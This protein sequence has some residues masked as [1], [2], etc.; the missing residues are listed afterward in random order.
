MKATFLSTASEQARTARL[1]QHVRDAVIML[2]PDGTVGFWSAGAA[3]VY[4]RPAPDALNRPYLDLLPLPCRAAQESLIRQACDGDE[5][6]AEWRTTN[7]DGRPMWLEGDFRP[8][9]DPAGRQVGCS[10][11]LHDVTRWRAAEAARAASEDLLRTV[12]DN[13]PGA[14]F[15]FRVGPDGSRSFTFISRGVEALLE[16]SAAEM[17]AGPVDDSLCIQPQHRP[18]VW[19][20]LERSGES[21][22]P[23]DAEY[24]A[25][26]PRTGQLKWIR[27]RATPARRP[28][29]ATVWNGM[30]KDATD[31]AAA[32]AALRESEARYRLLT[33]HATDLIARLTPGGDF[34]Y[35]SAAT[36]TLFGT[37]PEALIGRHVRELVHRDDLPRVLEVFGHLAAGLPADTFAH[38]CRAADG[39]PVW[40]EST[41]RAVRDAHGHLT[42]IVAVTRSTEDRR[43]LEAKVQKSQRLEAVGRLAGGVAHDFNNLL[44]VINGFS[45]M[46][47]RGLSRPDPTRI[48]AQVQEIHKAGERASGLTRQLL[49]F[50]RQ[51][52]QTRTSVN[53]ND[54]IEE[55]TKL[56]ARVIGEDI[57]VE[58]DLDPD[59]GAIHADVGQIEQVLMNLALNARDA[60]EDG[61]VL[62]LGSRAVRFE[63]AP[64]EDLPPG[65]YAMLRVTDTGTGMDEATRARAFEPFFTT[66]EM[67][68]GTGLGLAV[69]HGIVKQ[70]DGHI[71]IES[72]PGKGTTI[73][74]YLPQ[75]ASLAD[76]AARALAETVLTGQ[77]TVLLVED[78]DAVRMVTAA[79]LRTFGYRVLEA[80]GGVEALRRCRE[81]PGPI[82]VLLTDV[83]MPVMN[84]REVANRVQALVPGV[85]TLFMSGYTDDSILRHGI[86]D[87]GVAFLSKPLSHDALGRKLR[88]VLGSR[89]RLGMTVG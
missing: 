80:S 66:K 69:V 37:P 77:E 5:V 52:V 75:T 72:E 48:A 35:A 53:L 73:R 12:T 87:D 56:L 45:E 9:T 39:S 55:T 57:E 59:L 65:E 23:W 2:D 20:A 50:G 32:L 14:V 62:T 41:A 33:E 24:L 34:L 15:Q 29:G 51:Q 82:H 30:M 27:L 19:A 1:F 63:T 3:R 61:G 13:V 60:M 76:G 79:M 89:C 44:T 88:E 49:A 6:S 17:N 43:R 38:R 54:V 86:L 67:G 22:T 84:G 4:G 26:T 28:D 81:H 83:V 70:S 71:T 16:R 68:K 18:A 10:I 58:T 36:Q 21:L 85:K 47:L 7:P 11:L 31:Q 64:E 74:V 8:V 40:C 25:W 78:D 46:I 42:E